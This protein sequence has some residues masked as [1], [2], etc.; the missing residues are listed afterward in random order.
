MKILR[1]GPAGKMICLGEA[2]S[3]GQWYI[4]DEPVKAHISKF[5]V[6]D[7]VSIRSVA[8]NGKQH[9]TFISPMNGHPP[10]STGT[11]DAS[12]A[13]VAVTQASEIKT[14]EKKS[15][16]TPKTAE[17][18]ASIKRQAIG[19]M[20]SRSLIALQGQISVDNIETVAE[21]VYRKFVE[22]VG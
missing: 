5:A 17:E 22:L 1:M 3:K 12:N 19:H 20:T 15:T 18:N 7:V 2:D 16:W 13:P 4:M 21:K 10:V 9:L 11:G 6:G 14:A 8:K